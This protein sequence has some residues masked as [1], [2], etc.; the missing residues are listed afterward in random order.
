MKRNNKQNNKL[1]DLISGVLFRLYSIKKIRGQ[2]IWLIEKL[3]GGQVYSKTLREIALKYHNIK[4]GMYSYGACFSF[5]R[6]PSGTEIGRYCSFA[7]GM[8]IFNGNHPLDKKSMHP[9]FYN[10][11]FQYVHKD[12]ILR[13]KLTIGNDVWIGFNA[14]ILPSVTKIGDGAV[15]GAGSIVTKDVPP[16]AVVAGNPA[17][18]IRYRFSEQEI[19][20][21]I[22]SDWWN[23]DIDDFSEQEFETFISS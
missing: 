2:V 22:Y 21:I 23:K 16:F 7:A 4:I 11:S 9:F 20:N 3:E 8:A 12:L 13:T 5:N 10:P 17:K 1:P 19:K 6:I 18:I 15:I 14:L